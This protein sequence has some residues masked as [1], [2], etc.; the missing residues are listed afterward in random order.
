[1]R[2]LLLL[3]LPPPLCLGLR[4]RTTCWNRFLYM[5]RRVYMVACTGV[6]GSANGSCFG[7]IGRTTIVTGIKCEVGVP[8]G[9]TPLAGVLGE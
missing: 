1:M 7:R 5:P 4:G 3:M 2:V 8:A 6:V 9:A